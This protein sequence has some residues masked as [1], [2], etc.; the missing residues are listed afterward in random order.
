V[1]IKV[2]MA[3]NP[4]YQGTGQHDYVCRQYI[5]AVTDGKN[6]TVDFHTTSNLSSAL[7]YAIDNGYDLIHR[8]YTGMSD[9]Y[10]S[11]YGSTAYTN[12]IGIIQAFGD[13]SVSVSSRLSNPSYIGYICTVHSSNRAAEDYGP[14]LEL[15]SNTY[16]YSSYTSAEVCGMIA[17]LMVNHPT[18]D[19]SKCRQALR[20]STGQTWSESHGYGN[21]NFA[22]ANA[23][24]DNEVG[25]LNNVRNPQV[26]ANT[27]GS[28]T[29]EWS[30]QPDVDNYL[31]SSSVSAF[32][33]TGSTT[34]SANVAHTSSLLTDIYIY[35]SG[36]T[37]QT[38]NKIE[39][40]QLNHEQII[41]R[42]WVMNLTNVS[43]INNIRKERMLKL[44][45]VLKTRIVGGGVA[46]TVA[47]PVFDPV[48]GTSSGTGSL[49][50]SITCETEGATIY[51]E[52]TLRSSMP[53]DPP[54]APPDPTSSSHEYT[55]AI[56][57]Y[58]S[59]MPTFYRIKAIAIKN[60]ANDS[61]II[62]CTY[63][64]AGGM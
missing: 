28:L 50:Y 16:N 64:V 11:N 30:D 62:S 39:G 51:Y 14:G 33:I 56:T 10:N 6:V 38:Y 53:P 18:W 19:F 47:D 55:G 61:N 49:T 15:A 40:V 25:L 17:Q 34:T 9:L 35:S 48:P 5:L 26:T 4:S 36:S 43:K 22:T 52:Q 32:E 29:L 42:P 1:A 37:P 24:S 63:M 45:N 21:V 7:T 2:L 13:D 8:P 41:R 60:G 54:P 27:N 58:G 57:I 44:G 3:S 12:N 23:Y 31:I 59:S 46:E 20:Q